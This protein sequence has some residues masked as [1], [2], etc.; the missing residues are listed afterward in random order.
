MN[1]NFHKQWAYAWLVIGSVL[2]YFSNWNWAIPPATWLYAVFLLRYT[3]TQKAFSGLL[4]LCTVSMIVGVVS[5]WKLL[6]IDAISPGVRVVS[7]IA[8]GVIFALPFILDRLLVARVPRVAATL[9]FPCAWTACEYV[10]SLGGGSWGAIAYTQYGNLQFMQLASI[11]GIWGLSFIVAWF[12]SIVNYAWEKGFRW[13]GFRKTAIAYG[14]ILICVFG[15]GF[16]RLASSHVPS[17]EVCIA[18]ITNP[19]VF[20]SRFYLPDWTDRKSSYESTNKDLAYF[21]EASAR[22]VR[23]GA[24]VVVWQEYSIAVME[25]QRQEF[26]DRATAF[27]NANNIYLAM[28]IAVFPLNYPDQP[29]QNKLLWVGPDGTILAEYL[30]SKPAQALEPIIPGRD[31][32]PILDT[33]YGKIASVICADLDYPSLL[34]Q[35]QVYA[36]D[37]L[38]IPAQDWA[39][40]DPLHT[41]MSVFRAIENGVYMVKST[42]GGLSIAVDPYGRTI[43]ASDFFTADHNSM[44]ACF[45]TKGVET[46]YSR[47]GDTFAWLCILGIIIMSL[48]G[49][50]GKT[51]AGSN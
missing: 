34:H 14:I 23:S 22:S 3:R 36:A 5:M 16:I 33:P 28:A 4:V 35:G 32:I 40:A 18:S 11:T 48:W 26:I 31:A 24:K 50:I 9:I 29:W 12:A 1:M 13:R 51:R 30:K 27:A 10:K 37:I 45:P 38:L 20:F 49:I 2:M 42:G 19:R 46:I 25:E 8:L 6:G 21:L 39:A 17:G 44:L 7:G 41:H 15:Y 47:I 43:N